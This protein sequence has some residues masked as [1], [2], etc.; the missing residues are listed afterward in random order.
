MEGLYRLF[1][2]DMRNYLNLA[3]SRRNPSLGRISGQWRWM[4]FRKENL[5]VKEKCANSLTTLLSGADDG[6]IEKARL[7]VLAVLFLER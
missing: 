5:L 6:A 4:F 7:D 3:K 1:P 2:L